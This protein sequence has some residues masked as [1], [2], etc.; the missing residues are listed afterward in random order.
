MPLITNPRLLYMRAC[1][2][3]CGIPAI[4]LLCKFWMSGFQIIEAG[5]RHLLGH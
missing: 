1:E 3:C 5:N 2:Y 4:S